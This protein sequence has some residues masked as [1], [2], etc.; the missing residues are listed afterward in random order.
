ML[1]HIQV[2][3]HLRGVLRL[4]PGMSQVP[5]PNTIPQF[6]SKKEEMLMNKEMQN[7]EARVVYHLIIVQKYNLYNT[8]LLELGKSLQNQ[9]HC[10][11]FSFSRQE[12]GPKICRKLATI[13]QLVGGRFSTGT[14][15]IDFSMFVL[16]WYPQEAGISMTSKSNSRRH[17]SWSSSFL[18][19]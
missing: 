16:F 19:S 3:L 4:V 13:I 17:F 14:Q 2:T 1:K 9:V 11:F 10:F 18:G 12:S 7:N 8:V 5:K 15:D 6:I